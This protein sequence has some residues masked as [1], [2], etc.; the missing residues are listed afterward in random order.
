MGIDVHFI[1]MYGIRIKWDEK[2][3][4]RFDELGGEENSDPTMLID[5][6]GAEFMILGVKL[7]DSGSERRGFPG[8]SYTSIV[9]DLVEH[10]WKE[11][12]KHFREKYPDFTHYLDD[13]PMF[14]S[15]IHYS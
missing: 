14:I 1:S 2:L 6:M 7:F 5:G 11:W 3:H 4:E 13:I 15:L 8:H 10:Q 12:K 9:P